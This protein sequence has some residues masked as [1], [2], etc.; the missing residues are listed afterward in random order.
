MRPMACC[1]G[2]F[3]PSF[4]PVFFL[5]K[6]IMIIA[7]QSSFK[8]WAL[9]LELIKRISRVTDNRFPA[10]TWWGTSCV[11]KRDLARVHLHREHLNALTFD[12]VPD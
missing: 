6:I 5:S 4:S 12:E 3:F 7:E 2:T 1:T 9:E 8:V 10:L 11:W